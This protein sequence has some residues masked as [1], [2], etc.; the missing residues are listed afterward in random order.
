LIEFSSDESLT[1][2][3]R[4][5]SLLNYHR[6]PIQVLLRKWESNPTYF[7]FFCKRVVI[8][9]TFCSCFYFHLMYNNWGFV[10]SV[11]CL[12]C[13]GGVYQTTLQFSMNSICRFYF[14]VCV[15]RSCYHYTLFRDTIQ[16]F[17][18]V[19]NRRLVP[20]PFSILTFL[21]RLQTEDN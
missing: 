6:C 17:A 4:I 20:P 10:S 13:S 18:S 19:T 16:I 15:Y 1:F 21:P 7:N 11:I 3:L 2:P 9:S 14:R 8:K 5:S 12:W